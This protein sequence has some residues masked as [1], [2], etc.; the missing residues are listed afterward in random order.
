MRL[1]DAWDTREMCICY[2]GDDSIDGRII[3]KRTREIMCEMQTENPGQGIV[4]ALPGS[5]KEFVEQLGDYQLPKNDQ[6]L[7]VFLRNNNNNN[8]NNNKSRS[9]Y[10]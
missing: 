5:V 10:S 4:T 1:P 7:R 2:V 3:L 9:N 6:L 8:N